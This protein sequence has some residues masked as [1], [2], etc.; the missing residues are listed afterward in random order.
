[1]AVHGCCRDCRRILASALFV[2]MLRAHLEASVPA[3]GLIRLLNQRATAQAVLAMVR[4][5]MQVWVA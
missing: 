1:M 2:M 5:P 3:E 4:D